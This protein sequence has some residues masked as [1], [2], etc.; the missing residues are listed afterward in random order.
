MDIN[1]SRDKGQDDEE[2]SLL[3]PV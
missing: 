2:L 3:N 1:S